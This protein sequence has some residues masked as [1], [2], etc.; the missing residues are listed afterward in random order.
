MIVVNGRKSVNSAKIL[1]NRDRE[2]ATS[3]SGLPSHDGRVPHLWAMAGLSLAQLGLTTAA[4]DES[5][6]HPGWTASR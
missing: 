1:N 4:L 3:V 6:G 5:G 2:V